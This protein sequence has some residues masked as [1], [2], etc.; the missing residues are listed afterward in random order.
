MSFPYHPSYNWVFLGPTLVHRVSLTEMVLHE[1]FP[2]REIII[3]FHG[4]ST[5]SSHIFHIGLLCGNNEQL[6]K[7]TTESTSKSSKLFKTCVD[8]IYLSFW[9]W[10]VKLVSNRFWP[11]SN[12]WRVPGRFQIQ[13]DMSNF[14]KIGV[15]NDTTLKVA[16]WRFCSVWNPRSL[17]QKPST[18]LIRTL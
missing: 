12:R 14:C 11:V 8:S 4:R 9:F 17:A 3:K 18:C 15:K 5:S 13:I 6:Q 2:S 10:R 1:F 16:A 7:N